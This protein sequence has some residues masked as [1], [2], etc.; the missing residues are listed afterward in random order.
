MSDPTVRSDDVLAVR[1]G[2]AS[3]MTLSLVFKRVE[4]T[5]TAHFQDK[6]PLSAVPTPHWGGLRVSRPPLLLFHL[7]RYLEEVV[8]LLFSVG[9]RHPVLV[10]QAHLAELA[11][12]TLR[13]QKS[14]LLPQSHEG[15]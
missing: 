5:S 13:T 9:E 1:Q 2:H 14:S 6:R 15:A 3:R 8:V 12:D 10:L 4:T 11:V 7:D